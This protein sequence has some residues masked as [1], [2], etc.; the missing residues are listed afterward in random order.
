MP[1]IQM[2]YS[3]IQS[4]ICRI[5]KKLKEK[6]VMLANT[7]SKINYLAYLTNNVVY[8]NKFYDIISH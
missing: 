6:K 4:F 3:T 2:A 7:K 5:I 8:E 1:T